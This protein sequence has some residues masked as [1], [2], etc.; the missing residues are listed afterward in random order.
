MLQTAKYVYGKTQLSEA[1]YEKAREIILNLQ[2]ENA[3]FIEEGYGPFLAAAYCPG[4][5][6]RLVPNAALCA[7]RYPKENKP[8]ACIFC[9]P[10]CAAVCYAA[11]SAAPRRV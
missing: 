3:K 1:E 2:K 6:H 5:A 11:F 7:A 10:R 9:R 8:Y 4:R